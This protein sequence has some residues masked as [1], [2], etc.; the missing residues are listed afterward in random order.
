ME[1]MVIDEDAALPAFTV[2]RIRLSEADALRFA[3]RIW[4]LAEEFVALP[5]SGDAMYGLL[6]GIYPT[7]HPVLPDVEGDE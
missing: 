4:E 1:E 3:E 2:R 6:A 7:D 5:R